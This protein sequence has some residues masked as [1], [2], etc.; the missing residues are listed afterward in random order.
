MKIIEAIWEERNLGKRCKEV[1]I[2]KDDDLIM[3]LRHLA[4]IDEEFVI[5]FLPIERSEY[6]LQLPQYGYF[7]IESNFD[8]V[9]RHSEENS[10]PILYSKI[11]KKVHCRQ[12]RDEEIDCFLYRLKTEFYF[13]KDKISIDY[14]FSKQV[15]ANRNYWRLMDYYAEAMNLQIYD[16]MYEDKS[17][18][19]FILN[20]IEPRHIEVY[21]SGLYPE[22]RS[23]NLGTCIMG[24]E[25][26]QSF[27]LGAELITLG[28]S[29]NNVASLNTYLSLGYE[30]KKVTNIFVKHRGD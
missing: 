11:L 8:L 1:H 6:L 5:L 14:H 22:C 16:V 13:E 20:I 24:E 19:Y 15:S 10:I 21:L 23:T 27:Q 7:Y 12:L 29:L 3:T 2:E 9:K 17:I 4:D 25:T 18:G 30:V 28:V 26:R